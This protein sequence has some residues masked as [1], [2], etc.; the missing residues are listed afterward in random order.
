MTRRFQRASLFAFSAAL[1]VAAGC[2]SRPP[3]PLVA[4][5]RDQPPLPRATR[6]GPYIWV[7]FS[8][9]F[10]S[11]DPFDEHLRAGDLGHRWLL[12]QVAYRLRDPQ[13]AVVEVEGH[14]VEGEAGGREL[15]LSRERAEAVAREL[16]ARGVSPRRVVTAGY[17]ALCTCG[18][19]GHEADGL[20][21][22][23]LVYLS[24]L[25]EMADQVIGCRGGRRYIPSILLPVVEE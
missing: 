10:G 16:I 18:G 12:D 22:V 23:R 2:G 6:F 14:A 4:N 19:R 15:E 5:C 8:F 24:N 3:P 21:G 17:G 25:R 13:I 20:H 9:P 11:A 1:V 7:G